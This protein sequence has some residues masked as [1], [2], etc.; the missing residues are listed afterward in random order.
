[1]KR[2][3]LSNLFIITSA[4]LLLA[5]CSSR[6]VPAPVEYGALNEK[7]LS[8]DNIKQFTQQHKVIAGD[9]IFSI[10]NQY[11]VTVYAIMKANNLRNSNLRIGQ[12]L[13][14]PQHS[15]NK[16]VQIETVE[17]ISTA[18]IVKS[19]DSS[20]FS[21]KEAPSFNDSAINS[22]INKKLGSKNKEKLPPSKDLEKK[23][24]QK[25]SILKS[26]KSGGG[27]T[28]NKEVLL[29]KP[30]NGKIVLHFH[31]KTKAGKLND[32]I[33]IIGTPNQM[34]S[35]AADGIVLFAGNKLKSYG[36]MVIIKHNNEV[37]T[38][39][40]HLSKISIKKGDSIKRGQ[41]IGTT[42]KEGRLHFEVRKNKQAVDPMTFLKK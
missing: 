23:L 12:L 29:S 27:E 10:A 36:N 25:L 13:I 4:L 40:C 26:N 38:V 3:F 2:F 32:G 42:A 19:N 5:G 16:G 20:D 21:H 9:T 28:F 35:A 18:P 41:K 30:L 11:M 15:A 37:M 6:R 8:S 31:E 7:T 34:I 24:D 17:V 14:I 22:R 1:M 39:Y 33:D